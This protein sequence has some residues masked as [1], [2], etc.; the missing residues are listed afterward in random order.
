MH[1]DN[2]YL[3]SL[4]KLRYLFDLRN[5][6]RKDSKNTSL[7]IHKRVINRTLSL[8]VNFKKK[9]TLRNNNTVSEK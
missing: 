7:S 5:K 8:I 4:N 1:F 3:N 6:L 9:S 2:R